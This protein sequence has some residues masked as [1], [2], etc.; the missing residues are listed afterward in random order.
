[1]RMASKIL[2]LPIPASA[3]PGPSRPP[4][5]DPTSSGGVKTDSAYTVR[6]VPLKI[7]LPDNAPV[8]QE[9]IPPLAAVGESRPSIAA[10]GAAGTPQTVIGVLRQHLPLLFPA[11]TSAATPTPYPIAFPL[12]Q[13]A[14]IPPD[15]EVAWLAACVCGADGW[16][17][18]GIRLRGE[19]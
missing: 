11:A 1:M 3:A 18:I 16:L 8:V 15:A 9:V 14:E 12:A 17:R 6:G 13:G 2:P 4:S 5:T 19:S 10:D 7:Y